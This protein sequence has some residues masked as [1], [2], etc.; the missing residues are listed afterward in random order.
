MPSLCFTTLTLKNFFLTSN[1]F[2]FGCISLRP[3]TA[4]P[5]KSTVPFFPTAPLDTDG[6]LSAL[7][8]AFSPP[9][10]QP[11]SR[12]VHAGS[13]S[14]PRGISV[15]L[16]W[17]LSCR[18]AS[19]PCCEPLI[20]HGTAGSAHPPSSSAPRAITSRTA[21]L[22]PRYLRTCGTGCSCGLPPRWRRC[23]TG[24]AGSSLPARS[25]RRPR[26]YLQERRGGCREAPPTPAARPGPAL[27]RGTDGGAR[28][29]GRVRGAQRQQQR[30]AQQ[31]GGRSHGVGARRRG[32]LDCARGG[33]QRPLEPPPAARLRHPGAAGKPRPGGAFRAAARPPSCR[34]APAR[35]AASALPGRARRSPPGLP[36]E[37]RGIPAAGAGV[38]PGA[39]PCGAG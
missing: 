9:A 23:R 29:G 8:A 38:R 18:S 36:V 19:I 1:L 34:A 33:G 20:W 5:G 17:T 6:P 12:S 32:A 28:S 16:P 37:R 11:S 35:T 21:A 22:N 39:V 27:T 3:V 7:P 30:G 31:R 26:R 25:P 2:Q 15:A 10:A 4:D 13:C 24:T 14:I